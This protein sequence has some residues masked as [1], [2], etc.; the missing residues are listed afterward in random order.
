SGRVSSSL[1]DVG[2]AL[3]GA[4]FYRN[5]ALQCP[6]QPDDVHD[7]NTAP[8]CILHRENKSSPL[9]RGDALQRFR[10]AQDNFQLADAIGKCHEEVTWVDFGIVGPL[11]AAL[12]SNPPHNVSINVIAHNTEVHPKMVRVYDDP[13]RPA[14]PYYP[15]NMEEIL[16]DPQYKPSD[17]ELYLVPAVSGAIGGLSKFLFNYWN[18]VPWYAGMRSQEP[19]PLILVGAGA[20]ENHLAPAPEKMLRHY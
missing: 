9:F 14:G 3:V 17:L 19:E 11:G 15:D 2:S 8:T 12:N 13:N 1:P 18:R 6:S 16:I 4:A 5:P 10:P 20:A 7:T